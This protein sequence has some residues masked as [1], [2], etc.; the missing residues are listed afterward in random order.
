MKRLTAALG[1][2]A[3]L[4]IMPASPAL[5]DGASIDEGGNCNSIVPD[6]NGDLTGASVI[7]TYKSRT[8]KSGNT[9]FTC[10]FNLSAEESPTKGVKAE[11]FTCFVFGGITTNDSRIQASPGGRMVMTCTVRP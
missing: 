7:G 6:A 10:H 5:A 2:V 9:N 4:S 1:A 8:T 3:I 11:G